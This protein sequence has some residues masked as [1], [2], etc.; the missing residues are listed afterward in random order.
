MI[1]YD[2]ALICAG[3]SLGA[4][5]RWGLSLA[6]NGLFPLLPPGTLLANLLGSF[7]MGA[8]MGFLA[9]NPDFG[10]LTRPLFMTG[11]L[12]SF[13]TFSTFAAEMGCLVQKGDIAWLFLGILLHAGGS[14]CLFLIG[15][16]LG[17][18]FAAGCK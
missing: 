16:A 8:A 11:F 18:L 9:A 3:A 7:L 6:L 17:N 1:F 15:F 12:G 2:A 14:I 10:K 13:T 5:S 4:L